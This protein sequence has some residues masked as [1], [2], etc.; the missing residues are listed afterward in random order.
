MNSLEITTKEST[1]V[2]NV[3][4]IEKVVEEVEIKEEETSTVNSEN[5]NSDVKNK[6]RESDSS[7][8]EKAS[9]GNETESPN[10]SVEP[11]LESILSSIVIKNLLTEETYTG[12]QLYNMTFAWHEESPSLSR[13]MNGGLK[14]ISDPYDVIIPAHESGLLTTEYDESGYTFKIIYEMNVLT[15]IKVNASENIKT[16]EEIAS[17]LLV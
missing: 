16:I 17:Y 11:T 4:S 14:V 6:E 5:R 12:N 13:N 2:K 8:S 9:S 15:S 1:K 10:L 3:E 7:V